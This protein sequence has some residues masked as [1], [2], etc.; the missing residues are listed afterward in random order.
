M[1][2]NKSQQEAILHKDGPMLVLAGPGLGKTAVITQRTLNLIE[3]HHVNPA[4]ILVITFT[5]AAAQ[6]MKQRFCVWRAKT[7]AT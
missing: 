3:E 6:E 1:N 2:F 5:R 7:K 4:N